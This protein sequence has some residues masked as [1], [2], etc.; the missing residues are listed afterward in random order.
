M[1]PPGAW[2]LFRRTPYLGAVVEVVHEL[3][4]ARHEAVVEVVEKGAGGHG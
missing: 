4:E 3:L 1:L 2:G